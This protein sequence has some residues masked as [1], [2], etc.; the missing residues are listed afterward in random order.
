MQELRDR[1]RQGPALPFA[2]G[3]RPGAPAAPLHLQPVPDRPGDVPEVRLR[4]A[5]GPP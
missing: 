2:E 5:P 3:R 4:P 1:G